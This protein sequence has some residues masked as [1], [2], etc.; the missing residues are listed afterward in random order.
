MEK[1]EKGNI[2]LG[3]YFLRTEPSR[4]EEKHKFSRDEVTVCLSVCLSEALHSGQRHVNWRAKRSS[5]V[6][7]GHHRPPLRGQTCTS[8]TVTTVALPAVVILSIFERTP[9]EYSNV[10]YSV[11]QK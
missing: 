2:F 7:R 9:F 10:I 4:I 8:A 6:R 1:K 11:T 5:L 3:L